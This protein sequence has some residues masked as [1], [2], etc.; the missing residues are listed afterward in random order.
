MESKSIVIHKGGKEEKYKLYVEDYVLSYLKYETG[1]L[2]FSEIYFYGERQNG[3]RKYIIYG[4]GRDKQ[5]SV[6]DAYDLLEEIVCRLTQA[7]P[8]FMVR[9]SEEI[10]QIKGF[11]VFYQDNE[12]MQSYMVERTKNFSGPPKEVRTDRQATAEMPSITGTGAMETKPVHSHGVISAQL[13]MILIILIAIV[14]NSANSYEKMEQLNQ[15]AEEVFFAIENQEAD[16]SVSDGY[17][18]AEEIVVERNVDS[19]E[20]QEAGQ[21]SETE[22][23]SE[24]GQ[25]SG[26][27]Q[28]IKDNKGVMDQQLEDVNKEETDS[29]KEQEDTEAAGTEDSSG[30]NETEALSRNVTRY[31]E[32]EKGDTLYTICQKIYGDTSQVNK[33][34]ELN[35]ISDPD[36]IR[37]GQKIILP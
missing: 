10:Y 23:D 29:E 11:D 19:M 35:D 36:R 1:S 8:V 33:I 21:D 16:D 9:E 17:E 18:P 26:D 12:A 24:P 27:D 25:G 20:D 28:T 37:S 3:S 31:Y 2:E 6:F 30:A 4:A 32:V 22:Q 14:I 13:G 34:C 7:G 15:S 5:I